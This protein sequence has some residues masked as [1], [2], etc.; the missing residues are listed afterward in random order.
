MSSVL[1]PCIIAGGAGSRLWPVSREALPKPFIRLAD[2][3][4]FLQKTFLRV[5]SLDDQPAVLTVIN[6]ELL[7]RLHDDYKDVNTNNVA[8]E[9]ILEPFGRNTAAAVVLAALQVQA[10]WGDTAQILVLPADH[11]IEDQEAFEQAVRHARTLAEQGLLV[12]FGLKPQYP[13]TGYGYIERGAAIGQD[14]YRVQ[15]F[16]EKPDLAAAEKYVSSGQ[17]LWNSG[18]FCMQVS[19]LLSEFEQHNPELLSCV[20]HS[21]QQARKLTDQTVTQLEVN[22]KGFNA[23]PNVSIDVALMEKSTKVAVVPCE[24]GWSDIGSWES[25]SELVKPDHNG[26]RITGDT[27]LHDVKH[28]YIDAS[29]RLVAA[30]GVQDLVVVDTAD[31]LLITER[32]R[33]QDVKIIYE[34]LKQQK[35]P[36]FLEHRTTMRPWGKYT[37]LAAA[38]RYKIKRIVVKPKATLSLQAHHHRSEHWVV[39]SGTAEIVKNTKTF[40]LST[41]ESA[42]ISIGEKHRLSNPGIVDLV[43]IEVQCGEYLGEDDI[44]RYEDV[45]GRDTEGESV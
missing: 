30:I 15:R 12:T 25:L 27:V 1:I 24:L 37:V 17:Y 43:I 32:S 3:E 40:L 36:A 13:E 33:S 20:R 21:W 18:M 28:C 42:F 34:Q 10:R 26:N 19:T 39:V 14:G 29:S 22:A 38:E 2:G 11:L 6:R 9:L 35:H 31:A 4:S 23:V 8:L 44:I 16:V 45:Y 7:F 5:A 41:N